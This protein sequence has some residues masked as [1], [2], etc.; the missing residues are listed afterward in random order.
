MRSIL[1]TITVLLLSMTATAATG[2]KNFTVKGNITS[3]VASNG[4]NM[5]YTPSQQKP[6]LTAYADKP[7]LDRV[8][9][10][11]TNG[12][13]SIG[14]DNSKYAG[15]GKDVK[16]VLKC[17][18]VSNITTSGGTDLD[19]L[20]NY[21]VEGSLNLAISG[22]SDVSFKKDVSAALVNIASSGGTDVDFD[23]KL[24]CVT[25]NIAISGGSD[26]D[27]KDVSATEVRITASGASDIDISGTAT[28]VKLSANGASS[29]DAGNLTAS[30][31]DASATGSSDIK[32]NV[33]KLSSASS[34]GSKVKNRK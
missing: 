1:T 14:L 27:L 3:I 28:N 5:E 8:T 9:V 22:G 16:I 2:S 23:G 20:G 34:G 10:T 21:D 12:V 18:A 4:I 15:K 31:G 32:C 25:L 26:M 17:P 7:D 33:T 6:S 30:K 13:L 19:I 29:I 11:L 24:K